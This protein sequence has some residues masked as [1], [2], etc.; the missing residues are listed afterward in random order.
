MGVAA[1]RRDA[2][3]ARA[4]GRPVQP[5]PVDGAGGGRGAGRGHRG[6][7]GRDGGGPGGGRDPSPGHPVRG[8][9]PGDPAE[10]VAAGGEPATWSPF[11]AYLAGGDPGA[12]EAVSARR[13]G[14]QDE[15]SQLAAIAVARAGLAGPD[16]RWLDMCAGPGGKARLLARPGGA[17]RGAPGGH[18]RRARTG[19]GWPATRCRSPARRPPRPWTGPRPPGGPGSSTGCW[20][21]SRAPAS[22]RCA[23]ARRPAGAG[24][25]RTSW[26]WAG[27]S[28]ACSAARWTRSGRVAWSATSPARRTGARPGTCWR[29][30]SAAGDDIEV[31][32]APGGPGRGT[33]PA[34]PGA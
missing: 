33:G 30:C 16:R 2:D 1:P 20:R 18:R 23:A 27:C 21:T 6:R 14:V 9:R 11:G 34:L 13:A 29:T 15:A 28:A 4:P 3:P 25:R 10:L 19:P 22:G 31:L 7:H 17:A 32:D 5:S 26:A 12:I 8:A 24:R